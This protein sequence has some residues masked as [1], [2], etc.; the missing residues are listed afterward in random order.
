MSINNRIE[1]L[2]NAMDALE[3]QRRAAEKKLNRWRMGTSVTLMGILLAWP[4]VGVAQPPGEQPQGS[5]VER[6]GAL[7]ALLVNFSI[8][9][10]DVDNHSDIYI[11]GAN[12]HIR[13]GNDMESTQDTNSFGNLIVG[14]NED[15]DPSSQ[16]GSH[17]LVVGD[18]HEYTSYGGFVAGSH[19]LISAKYASVSGGRGNTASGVYSSVTGGVVNTASGSQSSV[20]GGSS[21]TASGGESWVSG[22]RVNA[23][24]GGL[25][26]V[27]GGHHNA[28][29]G[30]TSSVSGG[31]YNV[32]SGAESWLS[33]G[34]YNTASGTASSVSGGGYNTAGALRSS[35]SGGSDNTASGNYSSVSGGE[36]GIAGGEYDWVAGSLF[37]DE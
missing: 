13:N 14:Y 35:V 26:S 4:E 7:E 19:N 8:D 33:G 28:A 30:I 31:G 27:S 24:S 25:T 5:L 18:G 32:A 11:T 12:L 10:Y 17:N 1:N 21:N 22:G 34:T 15:S 37:E 29:V 20:T 6:V 16:T 3:H 9:T 36:L 23:A 2:E